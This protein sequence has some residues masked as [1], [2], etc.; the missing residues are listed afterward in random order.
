MT[1]YLI[2]KSVDFEYSKEDFI[3]ALIAT[4]N[5]KDYEQY[6]EFNKEFSIDY[7]NNI[8]INY[9]RYTTQERQAIYNETETKTEQGLIFKTRTLDKYVD[10]IINNVL[11]FIDDT[12]LINFIHNHEYNEDENY[13]NKS[14]QKFNSFKHIEFISLIKM[15]LSSFISFDSLNNILKINGHSP[16]EIVSKYC[17]DNNHDIQCI[18]S[19]EVIRDSNFHNGHL[20]EYS[21]NLLTFNLKEYNNIVMNKIF[22]NEEL[23]KDLKNNLNKYIIFS[24]SSIFPEELKVIYNTFNI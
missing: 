13:K 4:Y 2:F 10:K 7:L 24:L 14:S 11:Y 22:S 12:K 5:N 20:S 21:Y 9:I 15:D 8:N 6:E 17:I 3:K 1:E 16:G 19:N 23:N 18:M